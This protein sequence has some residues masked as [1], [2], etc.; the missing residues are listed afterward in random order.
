MAAGPKTNSTP[1]A[2]NFPWSSSIPSMPT[3]I[4]PATKPPS[5]PTSSTKSPP[6]KPP[7]DFR[8]MPNGRVWIS[9]ERRSQCA[10]P[11]QLLAHA[12]IAPT[13]GSDLWH[14][15]RTLRNPI[16]SRHRRHGRSLPR[17]GYPPGSYR[18]GQ[19]SRFSPFFFPGIQA[20]HGTRGQG[21]L[22]AQPSPH[23][24]SL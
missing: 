12:I 19:S 18:G 3:W 23:L 11:I 21:H 10:Y 14:E 16:S 17:P 9:L 6:N 2:P 22:V 8:S 4:S 7:A 20:A 13:H 1:S 15:T 5:D 24:P